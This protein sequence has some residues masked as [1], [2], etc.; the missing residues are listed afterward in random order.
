MRQGRRL[1]CR[2]ILHRILWGSLLQKA[3]KEYKIENI[4]KKKV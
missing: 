2:R 4:V 1:S 3:D